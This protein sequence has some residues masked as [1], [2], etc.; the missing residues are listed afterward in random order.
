MDPCFLACVDSELLM[1]GWKDTDRIELI[2]RINF[3]VN[4]FR[5]QLYVDHMS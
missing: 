5:V 1:A 4:V 2:K 3:C